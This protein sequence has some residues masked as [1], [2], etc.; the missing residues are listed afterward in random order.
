MERVKD[1]L[2]K[3]I[4]KTNESFEVKTQ[5]LE[6]D[7]KDKYELFRKEYKQQIAELKESIGDWVFKAEEDA[8]SR[9]NEKSIVERLIVLE[10]LTSSLKDDT[11]KL[12]EKAR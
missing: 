1:V 11:K 2:T 7:S 6:K 4:K 8:K 9:V 10:V 12:K 3:Q 5:A